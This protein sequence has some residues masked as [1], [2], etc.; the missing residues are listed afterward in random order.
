MTLSISILIS[1]KAK[2]NLYIQKDLQPL[3]DKES[4]MSGMI[5]KLLREHYNKVG[6]RVELNTINQE[7]KR[8]GK[9]EIQPEPM[10]DRILECP[11]GH[12]IPEGRDRCLGK[13][14]KYG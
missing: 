5:N 13:K 2:Y 14:C 1:M 9:L 8:P 10:L 4:N 3:L 6:K 7:P 12:R 11:N